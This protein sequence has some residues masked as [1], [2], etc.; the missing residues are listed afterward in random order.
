LAAN[1]LQKTEGEGRQLDDELSQRITRDEQD[2]AVAQRLAGP[3]MGATA[4]HLGPPIKWPV[5][6]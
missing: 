2:L 5:V 6:Q 4:G 1:P 3:D